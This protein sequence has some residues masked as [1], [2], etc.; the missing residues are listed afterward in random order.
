LFVSNGIPL[1]FEDLKTAQVTEDLSLKTPVQMDK[2]LAE[3]DKR[4]R[5][6]LYNYEEMK[7]YLHSISY[8]CMGYGS[9]IQK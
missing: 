5:T 1:Q 2:S 9:H 4:L 7:E 6:G 3:R 8:K